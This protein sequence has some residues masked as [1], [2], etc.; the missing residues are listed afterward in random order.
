MIERRDEALVPLPVDSQPQWFGYGHGGV[1]I[2]LLLFY[3]AFL[4]FFTWY[5]LE[6]QLPDY[7]DEGPGRQAQES[8]GE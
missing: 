4:V 8:P 3:L 1:P 5:T 7:L 2:L 6:N